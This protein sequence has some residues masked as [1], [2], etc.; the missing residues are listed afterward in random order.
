[1]QRRLGLPQCGLPEYALQVSHAPS[2]AH[3]ARLILTLSLAATVGLGIGRFAYALV[4]PD[5]RESLH[6][7][8][9]AAGF[10]NTV[11]AAGYLGGAMVASQLIR[12]VGWSLTLRGGTLACL[13]SLALCAIT[14]D[15]VLLALARLV[16]GV[17][18]AAGFVAGGA[19]AAQIAQSRPERAN[20]LLSLFYAG[21][22]LGIVAS[23]LIAPFVLQAFGT[24]SWWIVWWALTALSAIMT[25]P[26]LFTPIETKTGISD[27]PQAAFSIMPIVIYLA[28]YFLFGA[29]Y[30]AY[31]T[32]MIA[33]VRDLGG[34]AV[35]QSAFWC[36]IGLSAFV[37]PWV[38]RRVLA[39]DRGGLATA[40]ILAV[41][42]TGA[43]LPVFGQSVGWLAVSA[44]VFGV[45]FF[46]VVGSTTAFVRFNY[47][48]SAW[49]IAIAAMTVSFGIGQTLG[50]LVVGAI[51]DA[52][53]SLSY[54]LNVSAA[55]L[56]SGAALAACQRKLTNGSRP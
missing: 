39:L 52:L 27:G 2:V 17:G 25:V 1:V 18:A 47:P 29:G 23:G 24:G 51:T 50:P 13:A 4:L 16:A 55:T 19:L 20:F 3:L 22:G 34:G 5:M 32:F 48:P 37:T 31:M 36:L 45:A 44:I 53:G 43:A 38:W 21:P 26:L 12:R 14:G 41:N 30:I 7:S 28:G 46:A 15:F 35:A 40:I 11:N 49:P 33:Y 9:S 56:A 42:A 8:Y 54:A 10:M 6:W